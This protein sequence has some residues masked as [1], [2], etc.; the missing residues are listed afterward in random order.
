MFLIFNFSFSQNSINNSTPFSLNFVNGISSPLSGFE[1]FS[2][3]GFNSGFVINKNFCSN[4]SIGLGADYTSLLVKNTFGSSNENWSSFSINIG[5]QYN[6]N[7]YKVFVN[8]YGRLGC[9][10]IKIPEITEFYPQPTAI[11][12]N[13]QE[14][15]SSGLNTRLGINLGTRVCNGL[16]FFVSS[17]YVTNMKGSINYQTRDLSKAVIANGQIDPDLASEIP[18]K[19]SAFSFS[20]LNVSFGIR[21]DLNNKGNR[22]SNAT[23]YNSSRSNR[24]TSIKEIDNGGDTASKSMTS[25]KEEKIFLDGNLLDILLVSKK[26]EFRKDNGEQI[27]GIINHKISGKQLNEYRNRFLNKACKIHVLMLTTTFTSGM[28]E[29]SYEILEILEQ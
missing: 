11:V 9:S 13:F 20:S 12:S 1:S 29:I 6:I 10:F 15:N 21:L 7:V 2:E 25:Q 22:S 16:G 14:S 28:K 5:P 23:D 27:N 18:F 8:L 17:E 3:T 24:T 26:F 4:F 19:N